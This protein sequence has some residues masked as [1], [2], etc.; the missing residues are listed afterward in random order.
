MSQPER[1]PL[2]RPEVGAAELE[3]VGAVLESGYLVQGG[4][5]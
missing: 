4:I 5:V 3:A 1:I 2:A